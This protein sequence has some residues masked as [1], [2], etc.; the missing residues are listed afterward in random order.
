MLLSAHRLSFM[1]V[2]SKFKQMADNSNHLLTVVIILYFNYRFKTQ[3]KF[4]SIKRKAVHCGTPPS[5]KLRRS[6]TG[7]IDVFFY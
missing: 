5:L 6:M 2:F 1:H 7:Y 3:V 4:Y